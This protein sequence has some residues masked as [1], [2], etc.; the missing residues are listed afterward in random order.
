MLRGVRCGACASV[1]FPPQPYGCEACGAAPQYLSEALIPARGTLHT[2]TTVHVDQK[3][4]TPFRVAEIKT[5]ADQF[6]RGRLD[7]SDAV[8]G[9]LV[10]GVVRQVEGTERVVF[11]P[12]DA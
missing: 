8:V 1:Q 11:V 5:E 12:A 9:G 4:T 6:V 3:L 2:L 7:D 10:Q